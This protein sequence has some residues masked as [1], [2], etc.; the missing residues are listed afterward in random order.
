MQEQLEAGIWRVFGGQGLSQDAEEDESSPSTRGWC[1]KLILILS[2]GAK[3]QAFH[4]PFPKPFTL[5]C[6]AP[7]VAF[8]ESLE[9]RM[10]MARVGWG[11]QGPQSL[12]SSELGVTLV[13]LGELGYLWQWGSDGSCRC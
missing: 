8:P 12:L 5:N 1:G 6:L 11:V 13:L 9:V 3:F 4:H 2:S 10:G 7:T